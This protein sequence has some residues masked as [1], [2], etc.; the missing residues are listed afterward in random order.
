MDGLSQN[1]RLDGR[2]ALVTGGV[3]TIRIRPCRGLAEAGDTVTCAHPRSTPLKARADEMRGS[4]LYL[5]ADASSHVT[6]RNLIADG[7]YTAS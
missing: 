4:L 2:V 1:F 7:G 6:G 3:G 5:A